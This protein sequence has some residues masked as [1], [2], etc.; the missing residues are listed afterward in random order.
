MEL[1]PILFYC[2]LPELK[3]VAYNPITRIAVCK[4]NGSNA[5]SRTIAQIMEF[6]N[7]KVLKNGFSLYKM[8]RET[9]TLLLFSAGG[10]VCIDLC[11]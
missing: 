11:A 10:S 8:R 3:C 9:Q 6:S 1:L 4:L 2:V 5:V 7:S